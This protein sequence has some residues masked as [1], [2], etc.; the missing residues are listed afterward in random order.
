MQLILNNTLTQHSPHSEP[1]ESTAEEAATH[2]VHVKA[3]IHYRD[4]APEIQNACSAEMR[5]L[6]HA[7]AKIIQILGLGCLETVYLRDEISTSV[8][9]A[10]KEHSL[11]SRNFEALYASGTVCF[12]S[13]CDHFLTQSETNLT[14]L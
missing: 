10:D 13:L 7:S 12:D 6:E 4:A 1:P 11:S 8:Y 3:N 9:R 2:H 5:Y 14:S